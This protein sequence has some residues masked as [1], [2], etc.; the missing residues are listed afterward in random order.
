MELFGGEPPDLRFRHENTK[1]NL[2]SWPRRPL[3]VSVAE[4]LMND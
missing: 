4:R 1:Q 2:T 3:R